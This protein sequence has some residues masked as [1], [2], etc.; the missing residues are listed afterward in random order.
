MCVQGTRTVVLGHTYRP[1][2][3]AA[4]FD[5]SRRTPLIVERERTSVNGHGQFRTEVPVMSRSAYGLNRSGVSGPAVSPESDPRIRSSS[6]RAGGLLARSC[7][8]FASSRK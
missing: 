8:S 7:D 3:A 2:H 6:D 1:C 4:A 5:R